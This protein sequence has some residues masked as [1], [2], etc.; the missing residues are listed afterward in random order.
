VG[1]LD[2][3][4]GRG[5]NLV[6]LEFGLPGSTGCRIY[7]DPVRFATSKDRDLLMKTDRG[8]KSRHEIGSTEA[9]YTA[10]PVWDVFHESAESKRLK[11]LMPSDG[12]FF[13]T[14]SEQDK[15]TFLRFPVLQP[16]RVIRSSGDE[17][18]PFLDSVLRPWDASPSGIVI[19][20]RF[21]DL[22]NNLPGFNDVLGEVAIPFSKLVENERISGW[23]QV[24]EVGTTRVVPVVEEGPVGKHKELYKTQQIYI[25]LKWTP[26]VSSTEPSV[27]EREASFA[28]QEEFVRSSVLAQ[29]QKIDLVESSIGAIN[30]AL[31][32]FRAL[33]CQAK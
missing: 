28:I 17:N 26:P 6:S 16:F 7:W 30:T 2:V 5:R 14:S 23:F 12:D 9:H 3:A 10:D 11:Q 33:L 24:L 21:S 8:A 27:G 22:L 4:V 15:R 32:M 18:N 25:S 29:E 31:G 20:V 19:E 13:E 1:I